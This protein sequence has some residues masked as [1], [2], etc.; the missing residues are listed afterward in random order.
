MVSDRVSG[1]IAAASDRPAEIAADPDVALLRRIAA[2][3]GPACAALLDRHLG[4]IVALGWRMLGSRAEAEDVAQEVFLR[5]WQQ[6]PA[7]RPGA[8]RFATWLHRVAVNL[9]LDRLRR[10]REVGLDSAGDPP[11]D[12]P[13]PGSALQHRAVADRVDGALAE[14]PERQRTAILLCHYQELGNAEAAAV[15]EIGVEALESLLSRGRRKLRAL[16]AGEAEDLMGGL[17]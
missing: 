13:H 8:A 14:L 5:A 4:R 1:D 11:G 3:D 2:G 6:A 10:R 15:M 9:C 16:L 7:W 17:Q 12:D